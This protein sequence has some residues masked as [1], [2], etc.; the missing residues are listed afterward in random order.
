MFDERGQ[1]Y[2]LTTLRSFFW[3]FSKVLMKSGFKLFSDHNIWAKID[4]EFSLSLKKGE[5]LYISFKILFQWNATSWFESIWIEE[6]EQN[7]FQIIERLNQWIY[8]S[9]CILIV[10]L[11]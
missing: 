8:I 1:K 9:N 4:I 5:L 6:V 7:A 11:K 3:Y 10:V 2:Y